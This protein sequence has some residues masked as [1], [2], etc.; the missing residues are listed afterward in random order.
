MTSQKAAK[1][2]LARLVYHGNGDGRSGIWDVFCRQCM[3]P[4]FRRKGSPDTNID[5]AVYQASDCTT[6]PASTGAG[7]GKYRRTIF[8]RIRAD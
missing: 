8:A 7:Q 6:D 4:P 2:R 5:L 1:E 3:M